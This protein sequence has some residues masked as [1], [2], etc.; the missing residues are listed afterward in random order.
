MWPKAI[1]SA[2]TH[3]LNSP[4]SGQL[5][6]I[7]KNLTE[8]NNRPTDENLPNRVTLLPRPLPPKI[9]LSAKK[10]LADLFKLKSLLTSDLP[11]PML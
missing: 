5:F 8:V 10:I 4:K 2:S 7:L 1:F 3:D 11:R 9:G 6:L